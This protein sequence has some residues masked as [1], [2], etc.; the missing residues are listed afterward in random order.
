MDMKTRIA[1]V[2]RYISVLSKFCVPLNEQVKR[3]VK[4]GGKVCVETLSRVAMRL[5]ASGRRDRFSPYALAI[6][7]RI[8]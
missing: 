4:A 2:V 8:Y 5:I 6:L 1:L 7:R 3:F